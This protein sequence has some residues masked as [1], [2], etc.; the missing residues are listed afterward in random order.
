MRWKIVFRKNP[1]RA[2]ATIDADAFGP[3]VRSSVTVKL[4]Q[5]VL[6]ASVQVLFAASGLAGFFRLPGLRGVGAFAICL[7]PLALLPA[8][9]PLLAWAI[10]AGGFADGMSAV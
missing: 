8:V 6:N 3:R 7:Q 4:P 5:L 1:A 2:S 10:V 9:L